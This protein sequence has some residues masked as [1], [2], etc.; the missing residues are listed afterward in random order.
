MKNFFQSVP[1]RVVVFVAILAFGIF[2]RTYNFHDWLRMNADQARDASLVSS[3]VSGNSAWPELGPKAGGT[4]FRLGPAFY[5]FEIISAKIFGNYP[6]RMAY[7]DLIFSILSIP[8]LFFLLKKY[9]SEN[10]SL[11]LTALFACSFYA[12]KYSRFAWNPNSTPFWTMLFLYALLE[13]FGS[14]SKRKYVWAI[15]A[16]IAIGIGVQLHTFLLAGLPVVTML[17]FGYFAIQQKRVMKY[18]FVILFVSLCFN[19][20]QLLHESQTNGENIKALFSGAKTKQ[21]SQTFVGKVLKTSECYTA[22]N[23]QVL[24]SVY[25]DNDTCD[26]YNKKSSA[27]VLIGL[28]GGLFFFGGIVLTIR[29][30]RKER[31][32]ERKTFLGLLLVYMGVLFLFIVPVAYEISLRYFLILIFM[33]FFFLGIWLK[34]LGEQPIPLKKIAFV[35]ALSVLFSTNIIAIATN[36]RAL[37]SYSTDSKSG[38]FDIVYLGE[39]EQ[40]SAYMVSRSGDAKTVLLGGNKAYLFK[41]MNALVY[42]AHRHGI[43]II[44]LDKNKPDIVAPTFYLI[45]TKSKPGFIVD[46]EGKN[47]TSVDSKSFG[48]FTVV[49]T[50]PTRQ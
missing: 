36:F 49:S 20:P 3:V 26:V 46:L 50:L 15:I 19:I 47:L 38:G 9:F 25:Y 8:L 11:S 12:F 39:M 17:A 18:F 6:D 33:P 21:E 45:S 16:G 14:Q 42:L 35:G 4:N 13:I 27:T 29:Y 31:D 10:I 43:Q 22:A 32:N 40:I 2:I 37:A 28:L 44:T 5:Y 24:S 41:A 34:F 1:I 23:I 7:A 30:I 48:R